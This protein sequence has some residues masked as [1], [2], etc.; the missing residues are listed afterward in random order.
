[1]REFPG[2]NWSK[3]S[4]NNVIRKITER[5]LQGLQRESQV[6]AWTPKKTEARL[7]TCSN[8]TR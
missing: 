7:T 4:V 2:K 5:T 8:E 1:V 3:S 6:V